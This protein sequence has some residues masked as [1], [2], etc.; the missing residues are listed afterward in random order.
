MTFRNSRP[1]AEVSAWWQARCL[2]WCFARA[3]DGKF[4]DQ[5]YL[6]DWPE[7]FPA[8]VHVLQQKDKALAPW[9]AR[10]FEASGQGR[11]APVFFHF[12]GLR[13][14][15]G[16]KVTLYSGY[17][18]G[19]AGRELYRR[20]LEDLKHAAQELDARNIPIAY[21]AREAGMRARLVRAARLVGGVEARS[22]LN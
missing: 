17:R 16:R 14:H 19:H 20:Y 7:R 2:E 22:T 21:L 6:D 13:I 11:L 3:E 18:I 8:Q 9:N 10:F 1:A 4:G 5:K 15:A 12:Q